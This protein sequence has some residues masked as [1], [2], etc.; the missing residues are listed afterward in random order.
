L[1]AKTGYLW[2]VVVIGLALQ[3]VAAPSY[4]I[5]GTS[6]LE[7]VPKGVHITESFRGA[8]VTISADIPKGAST[9][10]EIKGPVHDD[11]LLRQGRKGGLWMSVGEVTV[12]GAPSV[13]LVMSSPD[14]PANSSEESQWGY[15]AL[16]K[17]MQFAGA[18][19]KDGVEALFQQ[20]I[21]LKES[22]G[23]YGVFPKALRVVGSSDD[24]STVEGQLMLPSNIAPGK[25]N[26]LLSVLNSGKLVDQTSCELPVDMTGLP[27]ILGSLAYQHAILYGLCAVI[28]AIVTGFVMGFLF[29][30]KAAH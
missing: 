22:E 13:Y 5:A 23:L 7:V 8:L 9:V 1:R 10:V 3:A 15:N 11:H 24:R 20:F 30:G 12:H 16:Q 28:I 29:K 18:M 4:V 14:L 6:I 27:G 26:I 25:Y 19:P 2:M 21:K 17:R